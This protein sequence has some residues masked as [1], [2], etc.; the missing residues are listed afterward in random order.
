MVHSLPLPFLRR[1]PEARCL[2]L[3][4]TA[5]RT[6]ALARRIDTAMPQVSPKLSIDHDSVGGGGLKL[7]G[8]D[9]RRSASA[10]TA[11]AIVRRT[12][13]AGQVGRRMDC[14]YRPPATLSPSGLPVTPLLL[15]TSCAQNSVTTGNQRKLTT[16][17]QDRPDR[18]AQFQ[19]V[20]DPP[21]LGVSDAS[22]A[23]HIVAPAF[24]C[25]RATTNMAGPTTGRATVPNRADRHPQPGDVG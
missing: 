1:I 21:P 19:P 17:P 16:G 13:P 3:S 25:R 8:L 23:V 4:S 2:P 6:T 9:V 18:S 7:W 5:D 11:G 10:R 12:R 15:P 14:S 24:R 22:T 20:G